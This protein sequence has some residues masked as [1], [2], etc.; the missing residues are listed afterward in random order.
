MGSWD[1]FVSLLNSLDCRRYS[2]WL[3]Q[4]CSQTRFES[5]YVYSRLLPP[6]LSDWCYS[7]SYGQDTEW[8]VSL[9]KTTDFSEFEQLNIQNKDKVNFRHF[10]VEMDS[11]TATVMKWETFWPLTSVTDSQQH[12][13]KLKYGFDLSEPQWGTAEGKVRDGNE[14]LE[15]FNKRE[16]RE[17]ALNYLN[18]AISMLASH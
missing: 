15:N 11:I 14:T 5:C 10:K 6:S 9:K 16:R 2:V 13:Q 18:T 17:E 1:L 3:T 12:A 8:N 7:G 4:K